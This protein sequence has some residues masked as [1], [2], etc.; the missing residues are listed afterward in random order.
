MR[1]KLGRPSPALVI[2][3]ISL[4]VSI[5]GVGYAAATIG[6]AQIK[7]NS[8]ASKDLKNNSIVG[9][10]VKVSGLNGTDIQ[11]NSLTG[12]DITESGLAKVPSAGQADNAATATNAANAANAGNANTVGG[13]RVVPFV[14]RSNSTIAG[15]TVASVGGLRL[16]ASCGGADND[17]SLF[18][19]SGGEAEVTYNNVDDALNSSRGNEGAL[20]NTA[21][22]NVAIGTP[23]DDGTSGQA[24]FVTNPGGRSVRVLYTMDEDAGGFDCSISGTVIG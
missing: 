24:T 12:A 10:D 11:A 17:L 3:C 6:S 7:N 14:Y 9:K 19:E 4:F 5:G 20:A 13:Q 15:T 21:S 16:E 2:A 8:V 22:V 1:K 23:D 18:N